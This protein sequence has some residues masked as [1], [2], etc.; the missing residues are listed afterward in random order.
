MSCDST[1]SIVYVAVTTIGMLLT[2]SVFCV[3]VRNISQNKLAAATASKTKLRHHAMIYSGVGL[4]FVTTFSMIMQL[5]HVVDQCSHR[6]HPLFETLVIFAYISQ[7]IILI[8]AW[9][10]RLQF[11]FLATPYRISSATA[12]IYMA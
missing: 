6:S 8:F 5:V 3:H 10:L 11:S 1:V 4:Y 12:Y 2:S 9:F 7:G